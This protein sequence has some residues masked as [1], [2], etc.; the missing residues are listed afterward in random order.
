M[1]VLVCLLNKEYFDFEMDRKSPN[2]FQIVEII[3][4][5]IIVDGPYLVDE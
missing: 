2:I 5:D 3:N 4:S 1:M